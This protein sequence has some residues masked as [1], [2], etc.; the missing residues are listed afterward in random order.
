MATLHFSAGKNENIRP[1]DFVGAIANEAGLNSNLIGPIKISDD[2]SLVKV[3]EELASEII[4]V[5]GRT[6]IKGKKVKVRLYRE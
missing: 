6:R 3:P 2:F 5:L 4:K 1:G